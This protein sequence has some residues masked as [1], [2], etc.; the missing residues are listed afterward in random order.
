MMYLGFTLGLFQDMWL[1]AYLR[2][3]LRPTR[4]PTAL[5]PHPIGY[6][7]VD[8]GQFHMCTQLLLSD[9][10]VRFGSYAYYFPVVSRVL[11]SIFTY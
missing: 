4:G 8:Y 5:Y 3:G 10:D 7:H 2:I 9:R 1:F 11:N 6:P